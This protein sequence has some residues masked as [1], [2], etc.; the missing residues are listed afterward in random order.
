DKIGVELG[1][2]LRLLDPGKTIGGRAVHNSDVA[3]RTRRHDRYL[4]LVQRVTDFER[5][6]IENGEGGGC[7]VLL[8]KAL[9][10]RDERRWECCELL[11]KSGEKVFGL[12]RYGSCFSI[13][14][15]PYARGLRDRCF[16]VHDAT[17]QDSVDHDL[18]FLKQVVDR[19]SFLGQ[20]PIG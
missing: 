7:Y 13:F 20:E 17:L 2:A 8:L 10:R 16:N 12:C 6:F 15:Y 14:Q 1:D 4:V 9:V 3:L 18:V 5:L 11:A 19:A